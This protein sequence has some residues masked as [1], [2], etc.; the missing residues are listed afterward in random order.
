MTQYVKYVADR[1][2]FNLGYEAVFKIT[3][4]FQWMETIS[5]ES[6]NNFFENRTSQYQNAYV[7]NKTNKGDFEILTD[8]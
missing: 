5:L 1:L 2:C 8:F 6:K 4:P 3:N 7:N